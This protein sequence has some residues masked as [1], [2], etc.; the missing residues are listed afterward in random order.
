MSKRQQTLARRS[1]LTKAGAGISAVGAIAITPGTAQGFQ[2]SP[3]SPARHE[4]D[5]WLDRIPGKHRL[6]F[7]TTNPDG[8]A[9]ATMFA[10]NYYLANS[11]GYNLQNQDLAVVII[12]RHLSTPFAFTDAI[13]T[14][15]G[16]GLSAFI[17][18]KKEPSKANA[19]ARQ[20]TG[21]INRGAHLAVCQ[22]AARAVAGSIAR[23]AGAGVDAIYAELTENLLGNSHMVPAGI[24]AV[25]RAQ[26]RGY[27]FVPGI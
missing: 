9:S 23:S 5:D 27:A 25:N 10:N 14:K 11:S 1:F 26:E 12:L 19:H 15:Y 6:M 20:L 4:Q 21:L 3:W 13:W 7:D 2:G 24:V 22:M 18:A 17:D 16:A 8:V